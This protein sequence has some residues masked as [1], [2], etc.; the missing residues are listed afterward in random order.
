MAP[1]VRAELETMETALQK[2]GHGIDPDLKEYLNKIF[3]MIK[4]DQFDKLVGR[5]YQRRKDY[6]METPLECVRTCVAQITRERANR[7]SIN[8]K[9]AEE[10]YEAIS[11]KDNEPKPTT[12][13]E[14]HAEHIMGLI[15]TALDPKEEPSRTVDKTIDDVEESILPSELKSD[16]V[17]WLMKFEAVRELA[18]Q[19]QHDGN[20][21]PLFDWAERVKR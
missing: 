9:K 5:I 7:Y 8:E 20:I 2:M 15:R 1:K 16:V 13:E 19:Y 21:G 12:E 17:Y 4:M 14:Q 18:L 11:P 10:I 6:T 3:P